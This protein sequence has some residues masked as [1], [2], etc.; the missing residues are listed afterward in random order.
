MTI[1]EEIFLNHDQVDERVKNFINRVITELNVK[2]IQI[3]EYTK[4][5]LN[6]LVAQLILYYKSID[7]IEQATNITNQDNYNRI[8]KSPVISIMQ[9]TNDQILNLLDKISISPLSSAKVAKLKE[10]SSTKTD[11]AE[12]LAAL[13]N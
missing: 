9:R 3:T 6:M 7:E 8:S 12:L 4:I 11:A 2:E 5:I 10:K 1:Q 13:T